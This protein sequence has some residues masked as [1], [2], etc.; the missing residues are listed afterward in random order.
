MN[1]IQ[2]MCPIDTHSTE[3]RKINV[4]D[5]FSNAIMCKQCGETI[6]SAHRHDMK[7]CGCGSVFVDGGTWYKRRGGNLDDCI[8]KSVNYNTDSPIETAPIRYAIGVH[9]ALNPLGNG[10]YDALKSYTDTLELTDRMLYH[11]SNMVFAEAHTTSFSFNAEFVK[12]LRDT[13]ER[14]L[15]LGMSTDVPNYKIWGGNDDTC[16]NVYGKVLMEIRSKLC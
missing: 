8:D 4:G 1:K 14:P 3:R 16:L 7:Y 15:I 11:V 10:V 9:Q 13:G 5:I 2:Q 6:E 12:V